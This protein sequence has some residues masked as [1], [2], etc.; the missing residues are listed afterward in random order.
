MHDT[1]QFWIRRLGL[2]AHPEG[3][4]YR[5]VY[6]SS[7]II[8]A[9]AL[10]ARFNKPH[11]LG[12]SIYFLLEGHQFSALHR[13]RSDEIWHF[14]LGDAVRIVML[15]EDGRVMEKIL[16]QDIAAGQS[17]QVVVPFG[18]W[19]GAKVVKSSGFALMGCTVAPGF[20]FADFELAER[21]S[22]LQK[23]PQ[24]RDLIEQFTR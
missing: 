16:G 3:G 13:I 14:Y 5:E 20:D 18:W 2:Q 23:L 11:V 17:F 4:Y 21:E 24:R 15:H 9:D 19:F 7:E 8:A 22:L 12:T 1:A 6:R 10:P